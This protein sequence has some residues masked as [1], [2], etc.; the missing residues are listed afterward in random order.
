[1]LDRQHNQIIF[2]CDACSET[3]E[4]GERDFDEA[5]EILDRE[6]WKARKFGSD[7]Y[8]S[9]PK[10]P[11]PGDSVPSAKNARLF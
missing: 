1:M 7:W 4:T 6:D 10:C 8:H 2:E 5:K 9:C 3:L 11:L